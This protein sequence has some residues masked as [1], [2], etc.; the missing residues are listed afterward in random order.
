MYRGGK[1][2]KQWV[3]V[4]FLVSAADIRRNPFLFGGQT[5]HVDCVVLISLFYL[6]VILAK[7]L[8]TIVQ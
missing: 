8:T 3:T 1:K 7:T 6:S 2:S 4:A 5:I